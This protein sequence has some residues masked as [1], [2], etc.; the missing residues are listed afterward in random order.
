MRYMTKP[1]ISKEAKL[2]QF[3]KIK[4]P[5]VDGKTPICLKCESRISSEECLRSIKRDG[6]YL[7]LECGTHIGVDVVN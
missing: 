6:F 2:R 7:H 3:E 1:S 5:I 4:T